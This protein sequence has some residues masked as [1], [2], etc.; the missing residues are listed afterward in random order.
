MT[1]A[2]E[3]FSENGFD[4]TTAAQIAARAGVTE[5]TFFRHFPDKREV[6]FDGQGTLSAALSDAIAKLP[7]GLPP[8]EMLRQAFSSIVEPLEQNRRVSEPRQHIIAATPALQEREL[9]KHAALVHAVADALRKHGVEPK[10]ADLAAQAGLAVLSYAF[11]SWF[12]DP[13]SGLAD[14]LDHAFAELQNLSSAN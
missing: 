13:A 7:L 11:R 5:R 14:H 10:R 9:A 4:Q 3:L 8:I 1:A 12:A 6:L 2:L